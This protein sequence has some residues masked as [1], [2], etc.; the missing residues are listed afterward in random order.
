MNSKRAVAGIFGSLA[1]FLTIVVLAFLEKVP[2]IEVR[3]AILIGTAVVHLC[4]LVLFL[5]SSSLF[6][7]L[8]AFGATKIAA[9]G[10]IS[11]F[12]FLARV[13]AG[14]EVGVVFPLEPSSLPITTTIV[15]AIQ[16]FSN[17]QIFFFVAIVIAIAVFLI[18][19]IAK[20]MSASFV[21]PTLS[22]VISSVIFLVVIRS[23]WTDETRPYYVYAIAQAVDF[24]AVLLCDSSTET[25]GERLFVYVGGSQDHVMS[26]PRQPYYGFPLGRSV[27]DGWEEPSAQAF[28][29]LNCQRGINRSLGM[30]PKESATIPHQQ[31]GVQLPALMPQ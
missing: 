22:A 31:L 29:I 14:N 24:K 25:A 2:A 11:G 8:W 18:G 27:A 12:V 1:A 9:A 4:A 17:L 26:I 7:K 19:A 16:V 20:D 21:L 30:L 13:Q 15:T 5:E 3:A 10:F 6:G 23:H 28:S